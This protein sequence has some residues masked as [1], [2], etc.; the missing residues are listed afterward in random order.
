[1]KTFEG[2]FRGVE[3]TN[4]HMVFWEPDVRP[5]AVVQIIHGMTEHIERYKDLAEYLTK[6]N[7][8]VCGFSL[9]G[10]GKSASESTDNSVSTLGE[11]GWDK[12]L[13]DIKL[14]RDELVHKYGNIP[15]Y[16]YGFSL[17]S[18]LLREYLS[19][20]ND[21]LSGAIIVGTGNQS[22]IFLK[23][24]RF[25]LK[26]TIKKKGVNVHT[27]LVSKLSFEVYNDEFADTTTEYDW[28]CSDSDS[29]KNYADDI[30][31]KKKISAGLFDDLLKSM[32]LT[33]DNT[34]YAKWNKKMPILVLYGKED[35][36]GGFG[37]GVNKFI[38]QLAEN[39]LD[40][41]AIELEK[42]R[43]DLLHE[44]Q[45]GVSDLVKLAIKD[46]VL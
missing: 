34:S 7:I 18:F 9:R 20:Y 2:Y 14:F 5:V 31:C 33:S 25:I 26:G 4:L 40:Y 27:K 15:Y 36:V 32:I 37:K 19:K 13:E 24:V 39:N 43:H 1:M 11:N 45:S 6:H 16:M 29:I 23:L 30:Y 10:H 35:P 3:N 41:S 38:K 8:A 17:G 12:S 28:L 22:S 21:K 44:K 42:A 46:F